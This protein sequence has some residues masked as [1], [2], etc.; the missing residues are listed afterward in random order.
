MWHVGLICFFCCVVVFI[1]IFPFVFGIFLIVNGVLC[2]VVT[3]VVDCSCDETLCVTRM[4]EMSLHVGAFAMEVVW[5]PRSPKS[6]FCSDDFN[7]CCNHVW[8]LPMDECSS[9]GCCDDVLSLWWKWVCWCVHDT[10][11]VL[12]LIQ[13]SSSL[14]KYHQTSKHV[15][16]RTMG[17]RSGHKYNKFGK[18]LRSRTGN[19][20]KVPCLLVC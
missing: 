14:I 4:P 5:S 18:W 1:S 19:P 9:A 10:V 7:E 11:Q 16:R 12:R 6:K 13:V 2:H 8:A 17:R 20:S 15:K 3:D